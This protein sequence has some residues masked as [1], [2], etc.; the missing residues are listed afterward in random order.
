MRQTKNVYRNELIITSDLKTN[1]M[2]SFILKFSKLYLFL[3]KLKK[4]R[5][6]GSSPIPPSNPP[7]RPKTVNIS[8]KEA[9]TSNTPASRRK[10]KRS[11]SRGNGILNFVFLKA[12]FYCIEH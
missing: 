5:F 1:L 12:D 10:P 4:F 7:T 9:R 8:V 2:S 3:F 11:P 6:R